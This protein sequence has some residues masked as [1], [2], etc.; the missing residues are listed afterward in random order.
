VSV[1]TVYQW[2]CRGKYLTDPIPSCHLSSRCLRFPCEKL[3]AWADRR[4]HGGDQ[5]PQGGPQVSVTPK[6]RV[7]R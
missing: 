5:N 3:K 7:V 4:G 6:N 1:G 2:V